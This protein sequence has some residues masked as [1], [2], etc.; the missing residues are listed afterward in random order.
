V[1]VI[2]ISK[3]QVRRGQKNSNS[4]IPQL[5]SA[6]F[7]WAVDSQ[8]LYI[9]NGS[10]LEGAP[11]VGN[12]K[13]LTEHDNILALAS[14]YQY[15]FNDNSITNT[16][17]RSLQ[18]KIDEIQ[19]SVTDFGA[20]GNGIAD[21]V[22]AFEAA[23]DDLF[24]NEDSKFKK[25]LMIPNGEYFFDSDL[26]IPSGV[27]MQGETKH[28]VI[29][30]INSHNITFITAEGL[31]VAEFTDTD[32]PEN[33][34]IS[35]LSI[36]RTTGQVTLSGIT[37]STFENINFNG[38]YVLGNSI[39]SLDA[40]PG[41]LF[42]ENILV[43]TSTSNVE[44]SYCTF[45]SNS[46]SIKCQQTNK[47]ETV[48]DF[49][50][51]RFF[52]NDTAVYVNGVD[53]QKTSWAFNHCTFEE[54]ANQA[55]RSNKGQGTVIQ[56]SKFKSVGNLDATAAS[57]FCEMVHFG[58]IIGN[59]V[60]NCTSDRQQAII[61]D[62]SINTYYYPEVQNASAT[63]FIDRNHKIIVLSDS[64]KPLAV[65]SS[66]HRYIAIDY[67][68]TI[69]DH[70]RYGILTLSISNNPLSDENDNEVT[71]TDSYTYSPNRILTTE[72]TRMTNFEFFVTKKS[73][74]TVDDSSA[75]VIDTIVLSYKNP[76]LTGGTGTITYNV[77]YG[78]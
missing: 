6:E 50:N 2:Q 34:K 54:I 9:G 53:E 70:S 68:L 69:G 44:F 4:G 40:E 30:N 61:E 16:K 18:S 28:G 35:N 72:G 26:S 73:N 31:G 41:A 45:Q 63:S 37:N 8:E 56:Q 58:E 59:Q 3:I 27:I 65:F 17:P 77:A 47:F 1:A 11:Y 14:S 32:R 22:A 7:A 25:I 71:L 74:L 64:V 19:V 20:V 48:I 33:L 5:S 29:L 24:R 12:T 39:N 23:F 46:I 36:E 62:V 51:C 78:V 66:Q 21:C 76:I 49:N 57:P 43:G 15:A 38:T 10:V 75:P 42:W 60:I 13:I 52:V 67:L 55:F